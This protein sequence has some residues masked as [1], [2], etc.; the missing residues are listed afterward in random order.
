MGNGWTSLNV[1][2]LSNGVVSIQT[3]DFAPGAIS[4]Q[5][6]VSYPVSFSFDF[7]TDSFPAAC[8]GTGPCDSGG[9]RIQFNGPA[10]ATSGAQY[11]IWQSFGSQTLRRSIETTA[12]LVT[13][14]ISTNAPS[15]RGDF[16]RVSGIIQADLSAS[17]TIA[18]ATYQ[19]RPPVG[20]LASAPGGNLALMSEGRATGPFLFDNFSI[21]PDTV[22]PVASRIAVEPSPLPVGSPATLS[23]TLDDT[24]TGANGVTAGFYRLNGGPEVAFNILQTGSPSVS[25]STALPAFQNGGVYEICVNGADALGNVGS[26]GCLAIAVYDPS[27][28]FVTGNGKIQ[29]SQGSDAVDLSAVG[30]ALFAFSSKYLQGDKTPSGDLGFTFKAGDLSFKSTSMEWLVVTGEPRAK[31]RGAGVLNKQFSCKFEVDAWDGSFVDSNGLSADAFGI[32]IY[33]CSGGGDVNGNR[34]SIPAT[35]LSGGSIVIHR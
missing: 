2:V 11:A 23:V 28:G 12:G 31:F 6:A 29:S 20:A 10:G 16:L 14:N 8:G 17:I 30:T 1:V 3:P 34:Y 25:I 19:F 24:D 5:L 26:P 27:A 15:S 21:S 33:S 32:R 9:W 22:G 7:R 13:D 4:R 35:K 18:G